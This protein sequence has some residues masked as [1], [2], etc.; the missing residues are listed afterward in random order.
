MAS[1]WLAQKNREENSI[2]TILEAW[3]EIPE[4]EYS[5]FNLEGMK[6]DFIQ[7]KARRTDPLESHRDLHDLEGLES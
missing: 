6:D 2:K 3:Q 5:K 4:E 1:I 7:T